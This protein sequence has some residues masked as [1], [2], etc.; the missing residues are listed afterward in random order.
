MNIN[1]YYICV[2]SDDLIVGLMSLL[3]INLHL[4]LYNGHLVNQFPFC[5]I[6]SFFFPFFT[7]YIMTTS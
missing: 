2:S 5:I 7:W 4:V 3:F 1:F 6:Y